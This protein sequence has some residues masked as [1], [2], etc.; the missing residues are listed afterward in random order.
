MSFWGFG[1]QPPV[2]SLGNMLVNAQSML[3]VAPWDFAVPSALI[4]LSLFA[5][6]AVGDA[7]RHLCEL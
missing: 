2:P 6:N 3:T 1:V 5:F 4:V 7:L